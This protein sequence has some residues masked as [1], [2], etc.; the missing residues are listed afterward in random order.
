MKKFF[1]S[2]DPLAL[3]AGIIFAIIWSSAFTSAR[4]IVS[5][6]PPVLA[7]SFR[8]LASGS[9]ALLIA[10]VLR[11]SFRL[12][13]V[14]WRATIIFGICQNAIYLGF[15]FI[16]MQWVEASLASIIASSMPLLVALFAVVFFKDRLSK[17]GLIGLI[18]GFAGVVLIMGTRINVG[19]DLWG[20]A[21][22]LIA[23][24]SLAIATLTVKVASSG[25]NLLVIVGLQM[26][27]GAIILFIPGLWF[28]TWDV[29]W[30]PRLTI[31]Y[32]YTI[33]FP[34]LIATL[35]WFWLVGRIGAIKA[36]TFHFLNPFFGV[37]VA[38]VILAEG[39]GP[40][41]IMGVTII[42]IGILAVQTSRNT[43]Q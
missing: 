1:Q 13:A 41:D 10:L 24:A 6:A 2:I 35:I 30:T 33:I 23:A 27:V 26:M 25:G 38:A 42:M 11:Q 9:V 22:C 17:L 21:L 7:L 43:P 18:L 34:G 29:T 3:I 36:A 14:Q 39:L 40:Y 16:A 28:E 31:A 5:E 32:A 8:F 15:N 4:I 12:T 37:A 19:A 20:V